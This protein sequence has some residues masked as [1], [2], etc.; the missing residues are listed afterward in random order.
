MVEQGT[1]EVLSG[2]L[3][4]EVI[5]VQGDTPDQLYVEVTDDGVSVE[6]IWLG[7]GEGRVLSCTEDDIE[8]LIDRSAITTF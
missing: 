3:Y 7:R 8:E 1:Y 6:E 2:D 4:A 5:G